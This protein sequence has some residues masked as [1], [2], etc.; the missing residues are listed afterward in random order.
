MRTDQNHRLCMLTLE[1]FNMLIKHHTIR[2]FMRR[3]LLRDKTKNP[4]NKQK[5][6]KHICTFLKVLFK[7]N[8]KNKSDVTDPVLVWTQTVC[9]S[10]PS[11]SS[12]QRKTQHS[13][14]LQ[15][16]WNNCITKCETQTQQSKLQCYL[17]P[18]NTSGQMKN[19]LFLDL[20][21]TFSIFH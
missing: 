1:L 19:K 16:K 12:W 7:Q 15:H 8:T 18:K 10:A 21:F 9:H 3:E 2:Q 6:I 17:T 20:Y 13:D 4:H 5:N 11:S 14:K